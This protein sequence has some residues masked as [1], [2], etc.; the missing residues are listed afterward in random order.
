VASATYFGMSEFFVVPETDSNTLTFQH[1]GDCPHFAGI[2]CGFFDEH[3]PL[4]GI[5]RKE[6]GGGH[7]AQQTTPHLTL[8]GYVKQAIHSITMAV[9]D[10]LGEVIS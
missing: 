4:K 9:H 6:V 8:W 7:Q 2:I 3:F 10:L 1:D 5:G